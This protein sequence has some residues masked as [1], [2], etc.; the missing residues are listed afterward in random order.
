M[1]RRSQE[2]DSNADQK[3]F[4]LIELLVVIAIIAMLAGLLIPA[5]SKAKESGRTAICQNN[6]R[7]IGI[8]LGLYVSDNAVYPARYSGTA[9]NFI[10]WH[11]VL[12]PYIQHRWPGTNDGQFVKETAR[13]VWVCPSYV[14]AGGVSGVYN[15]GA[16]TAGSYAY[17]R[18]GSGGP[19]W[20]NPCLGL[21]A[22]M[23]ALPGNQFLT[24]APT[25]TKDSDVVQPA[26]L[27][28][29]GDSVMMKGQ[30]F[31]DAALS[32]HGFDELEAGLNGGIR[33]E[34]GLPVLYAGAG[35]FT[36]QDAMKRR[37]RGEFNV[38]LA[39]T[40]IEK[41]KV[42]KFYYPTDSVYRRWNI[43]NEPHPLHPVPG[44]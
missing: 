23:L 13:G 6:L 5:L 20:V 26:D 2:N 33:G 3:A 37:H 40:H 28:A 14:R 30:N 9:P 31:F 4:T 1:A 36:D 41:K 16:D 11:R 35:V 25:C 27:F 15:L 42:T 43:D 18:N 10:G 7:Q 39:D 24:A 34:F 22:S 17:N 12:Y 32:P 29:V 19:D 21:G 38:V 8:A 44:L